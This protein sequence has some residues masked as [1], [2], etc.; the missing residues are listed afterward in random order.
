M[1]NFTIKGQ[2]LYT[3]K[4][5]GCLSI[6]IGCAVSIPIILL[7]LYVGFYLMLVCSIAD[8]ITQIQTEVSA[9]ALAWNIAK[10]ICFEVP[11]ALG[12]WCGIL[13]GGVIGLV[14]QK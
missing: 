13:I 5:P 3:N 1:K 6:I 10:I 14:G 11:I 12:L 8:I 4:S 2:T 9:T 7:G